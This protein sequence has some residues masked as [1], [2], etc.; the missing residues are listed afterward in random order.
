MNV[1]TSQQSKLVDNSS[2][3]DIGEFYI[4]M[5]YEWENALKRSHMDNL[6]HTLPTLG[7][8]WMIF[9]PKYY[10]EVIKNTAR[11]VIGSTNV[12]NFK[13]NKDKILFSRIES[14]TDSNIRTLA[15]FNHVEQTRL[16]K[17]IFFNHINKIFASISAMVGFVIMFDK[18]FQTDFAFKL[19][20]FFSTIYDE[21]S[22]FMLQFLLQIG[23][24]IVL[25]T[26]FSLFVIKTKL[27]RSKYVG[28]S[29]YVV[30]QSRNIS[31]TVL[32]E[33]K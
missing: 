10:F 8:F 4:E 18:A 9:S 1:S 32:S 15:A 30:M 19:I 33:F 29:I 2:C 27:E 14:L 20:S 12:F 23:V 26:I 6:K 24:L 5:M 22:F 28:H 31:I 11:Y 25:N 3:L 13:L 17:L 7:R 16:Q 21:S